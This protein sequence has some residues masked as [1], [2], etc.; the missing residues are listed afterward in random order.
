MEA[1]ELELL[2]AVGD[3][4][5]ACHE[6]FEDTLEMISGWRGYTSGEVMQILLN[7]KEKYQNDPEYIKLRKKF[8]KEFPI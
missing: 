7:V 4:F 6:D 2:T 3:C 8:P 5:N 1:K